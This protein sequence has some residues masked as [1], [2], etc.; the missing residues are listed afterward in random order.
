MRPSQE[1]LLAV[2]ASYLFTG[3]LSPQ[4]ECQSTEGRILYVFVS[5]VSLNIAGAQLVILLVVGQ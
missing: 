2:V 3:I 5:P 4:L 1:D